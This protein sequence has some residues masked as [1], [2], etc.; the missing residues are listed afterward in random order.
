MT[1]DQTDAGIGQLVR[2]YAE[3]KKKE[4]VL[5]D[6]LDDFQVELWAL[7]GALK[8][9]PSTVEPSS[10]PDLDQFKMVVAE[11]QEV[12]TEKNRREECVKKAGLGDL[13]Q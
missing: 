3:T 13:I 10:L 8:N 9:H 5:K 7:A 2:R 1:Q 6:K 12:L 11:Y 4:A